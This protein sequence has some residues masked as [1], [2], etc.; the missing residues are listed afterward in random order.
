MSPA[1]HTLPLGVANAFILKDQGTVLVDC[2]PPK[3]VDAFI[4]QLSAARIE[5]QDIRLIIIT[6]GHWDHIGSAAQI[7]QMTGAK[8]LMH[9]KERKWLE[10]LYT[11][12]PQGVG[13]WG[14]FLAKTMAAV[15]TPFIHVHSARV[16]IGFDAE[17][18]SL[19]PYGI[20]GRIVYTPGHTAG[21]ISVLL[22]SGEAVVGD[23]AMN[24]LPMRLSPGLPVFAESLFQLMESWRMLL[25]Q[26]VRTIYPSHGGPFSPDV[27]R[28]AVS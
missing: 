17:E 24:S 5:P 6:H 1:I 4:K 12:P 23:M 13:G 25:R 11:A 3:K 7:K 16:D 26:D 21:S 2:G 27:M 18:L 10:D 8:I 15:M 20:A 9:Q 28:R 19:E 14:R 22:D